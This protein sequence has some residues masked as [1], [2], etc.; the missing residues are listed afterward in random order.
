VARELI[1]RQRDDV[2]AV[3]AGELAG[4]EAAERGELTE[5]L[6]AAV[7]PSTW[8]HL[9]ASRGL[10][11]ARARAVMQRSLAALLR[12]AGVESKGGSA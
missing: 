11:L 3:F 6:A 4:L 12:D 2:A 9:R 8:E 7:S 1:R 10:S 5:A